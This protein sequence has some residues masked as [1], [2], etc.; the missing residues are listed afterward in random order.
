MCC[1]VHF[2]TNCSCKL[3][4][5]NFISSNTIASLEAISFKCRCIIRKNQQAIWR[6]ELHFGYEINLDRF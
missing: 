2:L 3:F 4:A 1:L 5:G 6:G